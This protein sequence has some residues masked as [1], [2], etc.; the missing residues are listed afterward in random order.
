MHLIYEVNFKPKAFNYNTPD[1]SSQGE[2]LRRSDKPL[3]LAYSELHQHFY[4]KKKMLCFVFPKN[5]AELF[6][7]FE[8]QGGPLDSF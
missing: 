6:G 4:W 8:Y 7:V 1:H 3:S 5:A 2:N